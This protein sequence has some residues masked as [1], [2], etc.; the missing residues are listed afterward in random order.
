MTV[1]YTVSCSQY[2]Y[3]KD[4]HIRQLFAVLMYNTKSYTERPVTDVRL[5]RVTLVVL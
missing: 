2:F 3:I 5:G 1:D 4:F